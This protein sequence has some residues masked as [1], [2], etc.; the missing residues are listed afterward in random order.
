[1]ILVAVSLILLSFAVY[2]I[3]FETHS[4]RLRLYYGIEVKKLIAEYF[5]HP[6]KLLR[7]ELAV[8]YQAVGPNLSK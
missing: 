7:D 5:L 3:W 4:R 6:V 8:E 2:G 1:M